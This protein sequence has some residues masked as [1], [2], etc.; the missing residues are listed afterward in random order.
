MDIDSEIVAP[1][2]EGHQVG[3]VKVTLDGKDYLEK[4]LVAL[5]DNPTGSL[6][7]RIVD[8]FLKLFY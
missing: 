3:K 4:P 2:E 7:R 1:V 6:G 5:Q 8:F